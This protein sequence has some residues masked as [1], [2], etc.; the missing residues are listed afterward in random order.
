MQAQKI[1]CIQNKV[2]KPSYPQNPH[3]SKNILFKKNSYDLVVY[4]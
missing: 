3:K 1:N 2:S 4:D